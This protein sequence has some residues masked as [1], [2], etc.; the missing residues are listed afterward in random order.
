MMRLLFCVTRRLQVSRR[1]LLY[2]L[3]IFLQHS[4]VNCRR[5]RIQ[6]NKVDRAARRSRGHVMQKMLSDPGLYLERTRGAGSF[7]TV[8]VFAVTIGTATAQDGGP[9]KLHTTEA[10]VGEVT[11]ATTLAV[12]DPMAGVA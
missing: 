1:F 5:L 8:A 3:F 11:Q 2:R 12:N 4:N 10:Y 7:A 6:G 9:Q